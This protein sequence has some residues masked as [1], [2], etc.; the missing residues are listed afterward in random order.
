MFGL[1]TSF[2]IREEIPFSFVYNRRHSQQLLAK[3]GFESLEVRD[4]QGRVLIWTDPLTGLRVCADVR[5]YVDTE[6]VEWMLTFTNCGTKPTPILENVYA[7]DTM[8]PYAKDPN[9]VLHRLKGS[10]FGCED[11]LPDKKVMPSKTAFKFGPVTGLP[12]EDA[13]PFFNLQWKGGGVITAIGW[14]GQ[15]Q[16]KVIQP[17]FEGT[18]LQARMEHL[19]LSLLPGESIRSPRIMQLYWEG[20]IEQSYNRFRQTMLRHVLPRVDGEV[21]VPPIAHLGTAA[22]EWNSSTEE[23]VMEHFEAI[24]DLGFEVYWLDAYHTLGGFPKGVGNWWLPATSC[25]PAD[26]FPRGLRPIADAA[27]KAGMGW[28]LWF[29][30][31]RVAPGTYLDTEHPEWLLSA[32]GQRDKLLNLGIPEARKYMTEFLIGA[33]EEHGM[34]WLRPDF[35][36]VYLPFWRAEDR[37][38]PNRVGITEIRHVEGLYQMFDDVLEAHPHLRIDNSTGGGRKIDLEMSSR[39]ICLWRTDFVMGPQ[40]IEADYDQGALLNQAISQSLN[41]YVPFS[42]TGQMGELPYWFRSG[43]NGGIPFCEDCRSEYYPRDVLKQAIEE[44]KRIRKYFFGNFYPL[45]EASIDPTAWCVTQY[46]RPDEQDGM[47]F[48]FRRHESL[49]AGFNCD[50]REIDPGAKY[51]VTFAY[52]YERSEPVAIMGA[53]LQGLRLKIPEHPGS[54]LVEYAK[55]G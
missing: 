30:P 12:S 3:W 2:R 53:F 17:C 13:C 49:D 32:E 10:G 41:R 37:K 35:N 40:E 20:D 46:H 29:E 9:I 45:T 25:L 42:A 23:N 24:K 36:T 34:D 43:F 7:L 48:A 55:I 47:I 44:G 50:L 14:T 15:W 16:V 26:R 4:G 38:D 6:A 21:V 8:K 11:W 33:V 28:L 39:S 19:H 27:H 54:V 22:Y 51:E 5:E 31:E 52:G 18:H 1:K